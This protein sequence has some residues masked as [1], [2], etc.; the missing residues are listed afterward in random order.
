MSPI[1]SVEHTFPS[2]LRLLVVL[3]RYT[4]KPMLRSCERDVIQKPFNIVNMQT[5]CLF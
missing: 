1:L 5:V 4:T 3:C 2:V